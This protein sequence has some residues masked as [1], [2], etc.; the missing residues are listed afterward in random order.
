MRMRSDY[1]K[2]CPDHG[3]ICPIQRTYPSNKMGRWLLLLG[4]VL[5]FMFA[6]FWIWVIGIGI[7]LIIL[8][9]CMLQL[10]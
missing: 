7:A 9:I 6:P 8:G 4:V 10:T 2:D 1:G 3:P 5:V